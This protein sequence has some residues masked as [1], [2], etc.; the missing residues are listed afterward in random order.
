MID[1]VIKWCLHNESGTG[2]HPA[3][4]RMSVAV[5]CIVWGFLVLVI[6]KIILL[7]ALN[8]AVHFG[9]TYEKG[10]TTI[11][12]FASTFNFTKAFW[13]EQRTSG[14]SAYS[15]A[16][17]LRV[18]SDWLGQASVYSL[19]FGYSPTM[20]WLLAP[21]IPFSHATAFC[22][23]NSV[24]LL[25]VWW[26]TQPKRCRFGLGVLAFLSPLAT[27]C[28]QVGQNALLT[29][30]GLLF[31]FERSR[32]GFERIISRQT[33]LA[34]LV[35]WALTAKP[36][37]ALTAVAVLLALR[38]WQ[39]VL[40]AALFAL[41]TT[42]AI[43]PR[44]G[45][46]WVSDYLLIL[47]THNRVQAD[48]A[49]AFS[50]IPW[51]MANLRGVL[52]VDFNLP[53]DVAS[54]ISAFIWGAALAGLVAAGPRLRLTVGGFWSV[55]VVLYLL[56]CPHVSSM[57]V[58]QVVLLIPFCIQVNSKRLEWKEL[59]LLFIVPLLPFIS[60]LLLDNRVIL[61]SGLLFILWFVT[62]Q[63]R[64]GQ[65]ESNQGKIKWT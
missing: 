14:I 29:G 55:G 4:Y 16:N 8:T 24:G 10:I 63:F 51:H 53:D 28:F 58:L 5:H 3:A 62:V 42:L 60:P 12:D 41:P 56:F 43:T 52:S 20:L 1:P 65:S 47:S 9:I 7:P 13:L 49:F 31:L 46:G 45:P 44:L 36:P 34:S 64:Y 39:P 17:H 59:V 57:E 25:A 33:V 48:P 32:T 37:L 40:L 35:L 21:L 15:V 61:F 23:F 11:V 19:S 54:R 38:Q 27:A 30:A 26:Q 2:Q 22:I 6:C 50:H 18:T